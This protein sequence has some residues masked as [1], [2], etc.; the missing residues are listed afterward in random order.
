M[1]KYNATQKQK[2]CIIKQ[3]SVCMSENDVMLTKA[4]HGGF[5]HTNKMEI[6]P[7]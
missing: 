1:K 5:H 2:Y 4:Y 3:N 7:H 6:H